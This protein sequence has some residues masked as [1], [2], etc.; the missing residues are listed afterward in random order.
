MNLAVY[1]SG[2]PETDLSETHEQG[3]LKDAKHFLIKCNS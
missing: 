2:K 3:L 1:T